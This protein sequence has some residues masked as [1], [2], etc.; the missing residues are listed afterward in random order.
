MPK[1]IEVDSKKVE[2][3]ARPKQDESLLIREFKDKFG[4]LLDLSTE[5]VS[6]IKKKLK[7]EISEW[8]SDRA[9]LNEKLQLWYDLE[10]NIVQDQELPFDGAVNNHIPVI[11]IFSKIYY[12]IESRSLLGSDNLWYAESSEW[13]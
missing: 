12:S 1:E 13:D 4:Q 2:R 11:R 10:Q 8:E 7:K 6:R 9:D 3:R 5:Q